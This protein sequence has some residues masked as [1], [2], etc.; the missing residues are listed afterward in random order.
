[1]AEILS[2][3]RRFYDGWNERAF[4]ELTEHVS[5]DAELVVVGTGDVFRGKDGSRAYNQNWADGFPDG[6]ITIDNMVAS[7]DTVVVEFTG[8]GTHTGTLA[9]S[10]GDIPATGKSL[11]LKLCDVL[12]FRD[13][14]VVRQRTYFDSGSMMAQLGLTSGQKATATS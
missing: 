7:G 12:E 5:D 1:M 3:A 9:T 11:T 8:R 2:I 13:D 10:M 14:M 4:D 6:R